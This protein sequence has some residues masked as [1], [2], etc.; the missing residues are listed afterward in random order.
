MK[1]KYIRGL[2]LVSIIIIII[3]IGNRA[4]K[5][6][7]KYSIFANPH[8]FGE[9]ALYG[10]DNIE[11]KFQKPVENI[12]KITISDSLLSKI[13][14][15]KVNSNIV[16]DY[17][18]KNIFVVEHK[19]KDGNVLQHLQI[20]YLN[21]EGSYIILSAYEVCDFVF[22]P[23]END[24]FGNQVNIYDYE[25]KK[26]ISIVQT[27]DSG[28]TKEYYYYNKGTD[29]IGLVVTGGSE[30][31]TYEDDVL[32]HAMYTGKDNEEDVLELFENFIVSY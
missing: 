3:A 7:K 6:D 24:R 12:E 5:G 28:L 31:Y 1:N 30:M 27:T 10:E 32:F 11:F 29:E 16:I 22:I 20:Q 14:I 23:K 8:Q 25:D 2:V 26:I 18:E 15:Q 13:D 19:S 17:D 9:F 4:V 21:K